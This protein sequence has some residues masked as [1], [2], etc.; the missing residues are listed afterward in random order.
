MFAVKVTMPFFSVKTALPVTWLS[1]FEVKSRF[2]W[3]WLPIELLQ[4]TTINNIE[5]DRMI[6]FFMS[7]FI[8]KV[9]NF[10]L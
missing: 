9:R 8:S 2:N 4:A 7:C 5:Q 6:N 3:F 10:K 1:L